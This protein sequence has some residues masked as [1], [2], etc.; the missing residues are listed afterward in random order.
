MGEITCTCKVN[1]QSITNEGS[2]YKIEKCPLC[3]LAPRMAEVLMGFFRGPI[4]GDR[5]EEFLR[6][7][8]ELEAI[9]E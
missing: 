6:V 8:K 1:F 9:N 4:T 2:R 5:Q 3:A 7:V